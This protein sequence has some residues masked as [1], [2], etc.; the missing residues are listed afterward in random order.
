[1]V[2]RLKQP[3]KRSPAVEKAFADAPPAGAE[4]G[5]W[6]AALIRET[7]PHAEEGI[8]HQM[9]SWALPNSGRIFAHVAVYTKHANLG[10]GRGTRFADPDG[11][12]EGSGRSYRFVRVTAPNAVPKA[13]L[14]AFI[15]QAAKFAKQDQAAEDDP[16]SK[17][18]TQ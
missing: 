8:Y 5:R 17:E 11:L 7:V 3:M 6:L 1:M 12:L 13:K 16:R 18:K 4:I 10:V 15:R 14:V 9:P 2:L